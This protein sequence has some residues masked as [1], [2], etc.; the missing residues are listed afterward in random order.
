MQRP[1]REGVVVGL[2]SGVRVSCDLSGL[3]GKND[4]SCW[5]KRVQRLTSGNQPRGNRRVG[6]AWRAAASAQLAAVA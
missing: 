1:C 2:A 5:A 3:P 4:R 6:K